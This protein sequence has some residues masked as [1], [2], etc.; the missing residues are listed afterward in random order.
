MPTPT[1]ITGILAG[2]RTAIP[3]PSSIPELYLS[4]Y[5]DVATS[6]LSPTQH[7]DQIGRVENRLFSLDFDARQYLVL[8]PDVAAAHVDPLA[9]FLRHGAAE[10]RQYAAPLTYPALNGFDYVYYLQHNP[11]VLA[12]GVD[13]LR[14]FQVFGWKEGRNPNAFFDTAGYLA[15]YADVAA[16]GVN[17]LEHFHQFGWSEGRLSSPAFDAQQ[18][19]ATYADVAAAH[20]DP[21][22]HYLTF[23]IYEGRSTFAAPVIDTDG[24]ADAVVEGAANGTHLGV[25]VAWGGWKS[26]A[27]FYTLS[28]DTSGG[29]FAIDAVT[30]EITVLDGSRIDFEATPD[31]SYTLTVMAQDGGQT[32]TQTFTIKAVDAAPEATSSPQAGIV[33]ELAADGSAVGITFTVADPNGPTAAYMLTDDANGRFTIDPVTGEVRVANGAAIDYETAPGHIYTITAKGTVGELSTSQTFTI[34]VNNVN[35]APGGVTFVNVVTAIDEN[36][37][38]GTGIKVADVTVADDTLGSAA[39]NLSGADAAFFELRGGSLYF[40][41]ASPDFEA[42]S[43]YSVTV[44]A[45]DPAV[46]G[47]VDASASFTLSIIDVNEAPTAL[48]FANTVAAIDENVT[49]GTGIKVADVVVTDDALGS[50]TLS[51]SGADAAAFEMR[52]NELYFIGASPDY[53]T[54]SS[55]AVTVEAGDPAVGGAIDAQ[56]TF[57]LNVTD[58]NEA[59]TALSFANAVAAIDE[60]TAVGT[61]IKVADVVVSDDALGSATLSLSGVD[62]AV[63]ELRGNALYFIGASPDFEA[64]AS[65]VVTVEVDDPAVGGAIDA[66]ATFTLDITDVNEAPTALSFANVVTQIDENVT[67]GTGIKVADVVVTDDALGSATLSLSGADSAF[68]ELRGNA[69][70]FIGAS[71][72]FE[73]KVSYAVTVEA[74]DP[75]VGSAIDA[76][77]TFTLNVTDVNEAPTALSFANTVT[78]IDENVTVGTGIKVADVVLTDDALGS[79]TLSLSGADSAAFELRGNALYFIGASPDFEVKGSYVVTVE[80]DDPAVGGAIDAQAA[81]TLDVTDVNEAPAALSFA[82]VVTAIDENVTVGTGIKVAD[83]VVTDDALGSVTLALS[84]ADSSLFEL[85]GSALYFIGASPDFE[86]KGKL[87]GGRRGR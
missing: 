68:F 31:H 1:R 86:T 59:P 32:R 9:H 56:A 45:D 30:G 51:L 23:G 26:P 4:I 70:Y 79:V 43:S 36:S 85:R 27:L 83:V 20:V 76:Q 3:T 73:A 41:G 47:P 71:P 21:L 34:N 82:N 52:G 69:L 40:I 15:T 13:P 6:G 19:L 38:V 81:F 33:D 37:S 14:H 24:M 7:Y 16:A 10:G 22:A 46:G 42:K 8:N 25:T 54:R 39:L 77:A 74:D 87:R 17:P 75:A 18:Y 63:F 28:G 29:G 50:E 35:E 49:V 55:Y 84:G 72:S 53:E 12:A 44:A 62:S 11:D 48:S 2:T 80:V 65:Y 67:V 58:V 60:N 66:Q 78:A 61:G 64:K 5:H 57:T